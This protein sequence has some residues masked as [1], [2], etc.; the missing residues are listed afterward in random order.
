MV[1]TCVSLSLD[2]D[3]LLIWKRIP[4]KERS[5]KVREYL[6]STK[7]M[8]GN[9]EPSISVLESP[10]IR[11]NRSNLESSEPFSPIIM[12]LRELPLNPKEKPVVQKRKNMEVVDLSDEEVVDLAR[13]L[14]II[15]RAIRNLRGCQSKKR[16]LFMK[17]TSEQIDSVE[18]FLS[19]RYSRF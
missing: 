11:K 2:E 7:L 9:L 14:A 16:R 8:D 13:A 17:L 15:A 12:S 18:K 3:T 6:R 10:K 5:A 1:R 19:G 4:S